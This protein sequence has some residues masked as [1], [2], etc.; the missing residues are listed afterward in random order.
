VEGNAH[1]IPFVPSSLQLVA[2]ETLQRMKRLKGHRHRL[3]AVTTDNGADILTAIP[4][5]FEDFLRSP[6]GRA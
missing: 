1:G 2:I 6:S 5:L 4:A 3:L